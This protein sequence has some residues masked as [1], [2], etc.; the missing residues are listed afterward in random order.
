ENTDAGDACDQRRLGTV[1]VDRKVLAIG[2]RPGE[3]GIDVQRQVAWPGKQFAGTETIA[4]HEKVG[5]VKAMLAQQWRRFEGD[6]LGAV[7]NRAER[8]VIDA[9]QAEVA[10]ERLG[11]VENGAVVRGVGADDHLRTLPGRG[12]AW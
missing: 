2:Q 12:E 3:L 4:T 10:I 7:R 1:Q 8:R 9:T 6:G 5:L 11:G